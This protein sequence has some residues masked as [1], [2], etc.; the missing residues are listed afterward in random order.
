MVFESQDLSSK[1]VSRYLQI[2]NCPSQRIN[3][4]LSYFL[5]S[6]FLDQL[7]I[8]ISKGLGSQVRVT[9][10]NANGHELTLIYCKTKQ[11]SIQ[12]LVRHD[13]TM[14]VVSWWDDYCLSPSSPWPV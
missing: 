14:E 11:R 7:Y 1:L 2:F 4:N 12:V 5:G 10:N 6:P 3:F 13:L 9:R 8:Q